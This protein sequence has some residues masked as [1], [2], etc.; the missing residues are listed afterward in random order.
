MSTPKWIEQLASSRPQERANAAARLYA[1]GRALADA[2]TSAWRA[3]A[4][5]ASLLI[6]QPA[7]GIAVR[8]ENFQ[9]IRAA[10][11]EPRL[12]IVPPEQDAQEFE[13]HFSATSGA[14]Q[15]DILTYRTMDPSGTLFKFLAKFGEGIQQVEY[16]VRDVERATAIVRAR[17]GLAPLYSQTRP[18]ADNTRVNF[19]LA[20]TPQGRRVLIELVEADKKTKEQRD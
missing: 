20:S 1:Q 4:E 17:F 5:F 18:G 13:L 2:A 14:V 16:F 9:R 12:S 10:F 7:V 6:G 8:P 19:F 15:L 11:G 3:D